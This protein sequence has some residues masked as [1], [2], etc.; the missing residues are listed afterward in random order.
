MRGNEGEQEVDHTIGFTLYSYLE[1][2]GDDF[3]WK[4]VQYACWF[5]ADRAAMQHGGELFGTTPGGHGEYK[6]GP[7]GRGQR[8]LLDTVIA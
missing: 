8:S 7:G 1:D 5:E 3:C 6:D 2:V 4:L